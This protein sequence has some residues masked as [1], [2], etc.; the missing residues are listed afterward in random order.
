[1]K[2]PLR[3]LAGTLIV[4]GAALAPGAAQAQTP[5]HL[6]QVLIQVWPEFD[7]PEALVFM[8]GQAAPNT[9]LPAG[10]DFRLPAGAQVNAVAYLDDSGTLTDKVEH[11]VDGDTVTIVSPNGNFHI[12]YYDPALKKD[13]AARSYQITW[14]QNTSVD[15]LIWQVEQPAGAKD[16]TVTPAGSGAATDENG[17][18][19]VQV[20]SGE[21]Q[22]GQAITVSI[23]YVNARGA[24]SKDVLPTP[25]PT[26]GPAP[27]AQADTPASLAI[28][29]GLLALV[30]V[31]IVLMYAGSRLSIFTRGG[32]EAAKPARKT[33]VRGRV[34]C[35]QCG[36]PAGPADLFCQKCGTKLRPGK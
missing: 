11:S 5:G 30:I 35:P 34:F 4:I 13:G 2:S 1:M 25:Q 12:E 7:R 32:A 31:A 36:Q 21:V 10:L 24:L 15:R 8:V 14:Q 18:P 26:A 16:F 17:L 19:V 20:D 9:T 29:G 28:A 22:A 23:S 6:S 3:G 33:S 27:S